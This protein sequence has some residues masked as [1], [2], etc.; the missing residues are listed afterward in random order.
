[1]INKVTEQ[2]FHIYLKSDIY[3]SYKRRKYRKLKKTKP[4]AV[5]LRHTSVRWHLSAQLSPLVPVYV[6]A[7]LCFSDGTHL[8][9]FCPLF[10][11]LGLDPGC[12][13]IGQAEPRAHSIRHLVTKKQLGLRGRSA[14]GGSQETELSVLALSL[15][16]SVL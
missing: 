14:G 1:M 8:V 4:H 11:V 6:F 16:C 10:F 15:T 3:L 13:P 9:R 2:T 7:P 12:C 5:Q